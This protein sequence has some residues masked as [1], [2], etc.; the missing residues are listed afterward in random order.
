[1]ISGKNSFGNRLSLVGGA[2]EEG[3]SK[4]CECFKVKLKEHTRRMA[5]VSECLDKPFDV[6][7][8]WSEF[9]RSVCIHQQFASPSHACTPSSAVRTKRTTSHDS[10]DMMGQ[11][12]ATFR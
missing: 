11:V 2:S 9:A 3:S 8:C 5:A 7:D 1:L 4:G 10:R 12:R 6:N